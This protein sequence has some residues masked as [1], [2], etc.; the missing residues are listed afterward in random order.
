MDRGIQRF[1][2]P[3]FVVGLLD[4]LGTCGTLYGYYDNIDCY[5]YGWIDGL[6]G[7][8]VCLHWGLWSLWIWIMDAGCC[9]LLVC[10]YVLYELITGFEILVVVCM[11]HTPC[12][13][14]M[15]PFFRIRVV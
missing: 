7:M 1:V 5:D 11:L 15:S 12:I 13:P 8:Y 9:W 10:V 4:E 2:G 6:C 3:C 14:N